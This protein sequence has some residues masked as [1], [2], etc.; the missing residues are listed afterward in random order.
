MQVQL[1]TS[2]FECYFSALSVFEL[3]QVLNSVTEV[4]EVISE[5]YNALL[6]PTEE[7]VERQFRSL[8]SRVRSA[9]VHALV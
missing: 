4:Q 7:P 3:S 5:L 2:D 1:H 6:Q 8:S 9:N